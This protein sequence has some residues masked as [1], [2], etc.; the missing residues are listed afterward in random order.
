MKRKFVQAYLPKNNC[1]TM[2]GRTAAIYHFYGYVNELC[3]DSNCPDCPEVLDM[4]NELIEVDDGFRRE[5]QKRS[6]RYARAPQRQQQRAEYRRKR[7]N[8][9]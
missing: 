5:W 3:K 4:I 8:C 7:G 6:A 2:G 1:Y 9:F